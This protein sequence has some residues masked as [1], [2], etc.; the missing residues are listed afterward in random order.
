MTT[1]NI[2]Y[3]RNLWSG[4]LS[5]DF[6]LPT[7]LTASGSFSSYQPQCYWF[8]TAVNTSIT[9]YSA[10]HSHSHVPLPQTTS[11]EVT[12]PKLHVQVHGT[13][14]A[15]EGLMNGTLILSAESWMF[16]LKVCPHPCGYTDKI[17]TRYTK[18]MSNDI[19]VITQ[20][21]GCLK[22]EWPKFH[23]LTFLFI[24]D[25]KCSCILV[26]TWNET[27]FIWQVKKKF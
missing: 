18:H 11:S 3:K 27:I 15:L 20:W 2:T 12:L 16:L 8:Y 19:L 23:F 26:K 9:L 4:I 14:P 24:F 21:H 17:N 13:G 25:S 22:Y 10:C 6:P 7:V 1:G 5:S